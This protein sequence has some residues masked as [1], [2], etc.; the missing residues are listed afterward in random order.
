[1]LEFQIVQILNV[2]NDIQYIFAKQIEPG[3]NFT[4][5]AGIYLGNV[6]LD[7]YLDMPRDLDDKEQQRQ[8]LF[9]FKPKYR[10]DKSRLINGMIV[11]LT[12]PE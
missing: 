4:I 9:I 2:E 3:H 6:E 11:R 1:M 12:V 5:K 10:I 8:D 7:E